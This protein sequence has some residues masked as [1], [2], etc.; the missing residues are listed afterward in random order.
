MGICKVFGWNR[1]FGWNLQGFRLELGFRLEF[2]GFSVR[3]GFRLEFARF[4]IGIG[5]RLEFA[6]F[7]PTLGEV[8]IRI[9]QK[10]WGGGLSL[11]HSPVSTTQKG[12]PQGHIK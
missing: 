8:N 3:I 10:R 6:G 11:Y 2:A 12:A 7:R 1:G 9:L 5:F 4:S